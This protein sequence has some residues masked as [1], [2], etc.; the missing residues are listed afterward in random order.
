MGRR[1]P[2]HVLSGNFKRAQ[3][4][5]RVIEEYA[6]ISPAAHVS[7][8]AKTIRFSLYDLEKRY[9]KKATHE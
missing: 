1:T 5:A 9:M 7:E 6:K 4:A 8:K 2:E 3:E